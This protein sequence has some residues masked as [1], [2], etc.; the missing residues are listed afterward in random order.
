MTIIGTVT[1]RVLFV[2]TG[3]VCRSPSAEVLLR[4]CA[5]PS[6]V[7]VTSAGLHAL[8]DEPVDPPTAD[9]LAERGID[10]GAHRGRQFLASM[11]ADADLVL[12]AETAHRDQVMTEVPAAFRRIFTM[13]EFGRLVADFTGGTPTDAIAFA[14]A[15]RGVEGEVPAGADDIT[16]PFG[17]PLPRAREIVAELA[18]AVDVIAGALGVRRRTRRPS[19]E[20]HVPAQRRRPRPRI[21]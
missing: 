5:E 8:V 21:Y 10:A 1:V 17:G 19:P 3:N 9:A 20:P 6:Q 2:C 16:D 18:D 15:A 14:A 4:A 13:K 7:T 11:A 12:T